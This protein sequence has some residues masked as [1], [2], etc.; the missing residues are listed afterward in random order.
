[1]SRFVTD[2]GIEVPAVTAEQMRQ[3]DRIA[4]NETGPVP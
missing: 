1:M 4:I 3:L 2:T